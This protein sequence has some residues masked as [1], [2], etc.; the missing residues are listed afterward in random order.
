MSSPWD[1]PILERGQEL[2]SA[3]AALSAAANGEGTILLIEAPPGMGKTRLAEAIVDLADSSG[4]GVHRARGE[5]LEVGFAYGVLR[6]ILRS[7][8]EPLQPSDRAAVAD[9]PGRL[10]ASLLEDGANR[11]VGDA[12]GIDYGFYR[13]L[14]D[15]AE[16]HPRLLLLDDAHWADLR[17]LHALRFATRRLEEQSV[18]TVI[19][20]RPSRDGE[21]TDPLRQLSLVKASRRLLL[22]PLGPEAVL[23]MARFVLGA[24]PDE[25]FVHELQRV[26]GG[27]PFLVTELLAQARMEGS[28]SGS[29]ELTG[30][31]PDRV[32]QSVQQRITACGDSAV[33]LAEAVAILGEGYLR[34]VARLASLDLAEAGVAADRL[35][36]VHVLT[37]GRRLRFS[38]PLL[39]QAVVDRIPHSQR[40]LAHDKAGRVLA[41]V[42]APPEEIVA[43][44]VNAPEQADPW[45]VEMLVAEAMREQARGSPETAEPLLA[46]ARD[47]PPPPSNRFHV[48]SELARVRAQTGHPEVISTARQALELAS[49]PSEHA[50]ATLHLI[51]TIGIYRGFRSAS[52]LLAEVKV[53]VGSVDPELALQLEAELLG[54]VRLDGESYQQAVFRL[55][56]LA[57]RAIPARPSSVLLLANLAMS[58]LERNE[59]PSKIAQLAELA[60]SHGWLITE[61]NLQLLYAVATLIWID[62]LDAAARACGQIDEEARKRGSVSLSALLYG[63]RAQLNLRRGSVSDAVADARVCAELA[64][65]GAP[66]E[67]TAYARAHLADALMERAEWDEAD[68]VLADPVPEERAD[69][70]PYYLNSRGQSSQARHDPAAALR[71]FTACGNALAR[72]GGVDTPTIFPW[73]SHAAQAHMH[74]GDQDRARELAEEE[75]E[76]AETGRVPGA[77]GEVMTTL[78]MIE[79]GSEGERRIRAALDVLEES[80]RLLVR[81][82]AL[83]ELGSMIRRQGRPAEARPILKSALDLAHRQGAVAR[84]Q[85]AHE[86]LVLAGSRPRRSALTGVDALTPSERRVAQLVGKGLT[87]RE[88][89]DTLFVSPRTISTH[90]TH[91]YQKLDTDDR[92]EL[93][94]FC[95]QP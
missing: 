43:H 6:Q 39:R 25:T 34:D 47:E 35:A 58:A 48:T 81:I 84:E 17:S 44:L 74:L 24:E 94:T 45:I 92:D 20:Y 7:M 82:R 89:A 61:G 53:S 73:R 16:R 57:P 37:V 21:R 12:L 5:D 1:G 15:L 65:S 23:E 93:S 75:L 32:T 28:A 33:R 49:D 41:D 86:E 85:R 56:E 78:G 14:Q 77:I 30:Q 42:G 3:E 67:G 72:R 36:A 27:N 88:I 76:L 4:F 63:L 29:I 64:F 31:V 22:S 90:L 91:I 59:H 38:H 46:R 19:T 51:R 79:G 70:N 80:P 69:L 55:E 83:T 54:L 60:L 71:N 95:Q 62:K 66:T 10:A 8:L 87:N 2:E 26:T 40:R 50:T 9:G 52:S 13:L 68:R 18:V 11:R